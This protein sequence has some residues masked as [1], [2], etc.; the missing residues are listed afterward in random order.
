MP[1]VGFEHTIP[2]FELASL[3]PR[4]HCDRLYDFYVRIFLGL[5]LFFI[6]ANSCLF[7]LELI[8]HNI[9]YGLS[10]NILKY[11]ELSLLRYNAMYSG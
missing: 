4:R 10:N 7:S 8:S 1:Q 2:A 3:R 5:Y 6:S 11:E 9:K